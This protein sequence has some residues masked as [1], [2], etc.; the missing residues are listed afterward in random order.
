M[1]DAVRIQVRAMYFGEEFDNLKMSDEAF[2]AKSENFHKNKA[3]MRKA[4]LQQ[5]C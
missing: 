3:M 1:I 2:L 5:S 4:Q